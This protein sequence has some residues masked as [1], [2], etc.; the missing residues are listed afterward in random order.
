MS[1][2]IQIRGRPPRSIVAALLGSHGRPFSDI[3][4]A[5][6]GALRSLETRIKLFL[7]LPLA[8]IDQMRLKKQLDSIGHTPTESSDDAKH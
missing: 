3:S 1:D 6:R 7:D 4:I 5:F 8:S 2:P